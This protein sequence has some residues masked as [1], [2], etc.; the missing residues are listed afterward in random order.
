[1]TKQ[2][3]ESVTT[4]HGTTVTGFYSNGEI[5]GTGLPGACALHNQTMTITWIAEE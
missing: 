5:S 2:P 1:M 4:R 3:D